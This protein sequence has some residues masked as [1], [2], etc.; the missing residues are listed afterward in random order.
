MQLHCSNHRPSKCRFI[1]AL[2]STRED[3]PEPRRL[4]RQSANRHSAKSPIIVRIEVEFATQ[5]GCSRPESKLLDLFSLRRMLEAQPGSVLL[6]A[7]HALLDEVHPF[8]PVVDVRINRILLLDALSAALGDHR[9]EGRTID[10]G[11]MPRRMPRM[12]ARQT[13]GSFTRTVHERCVW[14]LECTSDVADH[15]G[16]R[17]SRS[18]LLAAN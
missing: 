18:D 8:D 17:S 15:C 2:T 9:I 16:E 14:D 10:I 7:G 12:T 1:D 4:T 11:E 5:P 6:A 13:A 3:F